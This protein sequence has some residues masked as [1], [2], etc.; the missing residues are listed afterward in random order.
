MLRTSFA[1]NFVVTRLIVNRGGN[2]K[3]PPT[4]EWAAEESQ[5]TVCGHK[6]RNNYL[7]REAS[8][9]EREHKNPEEISHKLGSL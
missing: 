3:K 8:K 7:Q 5:L 9:I 2:F 1:I 6:V 4:S